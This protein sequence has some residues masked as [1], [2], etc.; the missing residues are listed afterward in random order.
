M[1]HEHLLPIARMIAR[2]RLPTLMRAGLP[3][4]IAGAVHAAFHGDVAIEAIEAV[5]TDLAGQAHGHSC[6]SRRPPSH[7]ELL[8]RDFLTD[9]ESVQ[10]IWGMLLREL[11]KATRA[12]TILELGTCIGI[13]ASYMGF[14]TSCRRLI[15]VEGDPERARLARENLTRLSVPAEVLVCSFDKALDAIVAQIGRDLDLVLIDGEKDR[16]DNLRW[17]DRI[18]PHLRPGA[19]LII[20]D[21][22]HFAGMR[23]M[24]MEVR[25]WS[26][27]RDV[28]DLGRLGVCVRGDDSSTPRLHELFRFCGVDLMRI[29]TIVR[30]VQGEYH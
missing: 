30:K 22:H 11:A 4:E 14:D 9:V 12:E 5:R 18:R 25:R 2:L 13:S 24:W 17:A 19:L 10:P 1:R 7:A 27:F 21:I 20:D 6:Y 28:V 8:P 3:T 26:G 29:Y 16:E 23:R 15:A